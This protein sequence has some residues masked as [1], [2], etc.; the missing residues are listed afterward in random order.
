MNPLQVWILYGY[1]MDALLMPCISCDFLLVSFKKNFNN[2]INIDIIMA[3]LILYNTVYYLNFCLATL[4][5][6]SIF[7]GQLPP[8]LLVLLLFP[9]NICTNSH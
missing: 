2:D 4:K 1:I 8:F 6:G 3:F 5:T 9:V 7:F